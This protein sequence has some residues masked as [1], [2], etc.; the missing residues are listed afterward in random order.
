MKN[1]NNHRFSL[2]E[3]F[4]S[5]SN[6]I[7][8]ELDDKKPKPSDE[9][10]KMKSKFSR[11]QKRMTTQMNNEMLNQILEKTSIVAEDEEK[12]QGPS[13][14][15][16]E[17]P[18]DLEGPGDDEEDSLIKDMFYEKKEDTKSSKNEEEAAKPLITDLGDDEL[19]NE[20]NIIKQT[21]SVKNNPNEYSYMNK[22]KKVFKKKL[23]MK[24]MVFSSLMRNSSSQN[25]NGGEEQT[26]VLRT[27]TDFASSTL[28]FINNGNSATAAT[29]PYLVSVNNERSGKAGKG[30]TKGGS[31]N[32]Y[33]ILGVGGSRAKDGTESGGSIAINGASGRLDTFGTKGGEEDDQRGK[34]ALESERVGLLGGDSSKEVSIDEE[35]VGVDKESHNNTSTLP[36]NSRS[37]E[38]QQLSSGERTNTPSSQIPK[39]NVISS[40]TPLLGSH[41]GELMVIH[42][43]ETPSNEENEEDKENNI[44]GLA[45]PSSPINVKNINVPEMKQTNDSKKEGRMRRGDSKK[46]FSLIVGYSERAEF[47]E[48]SGSGEGFGS[49]KLF[50]NR[51]FGA[52]LNKHRSLDSSTVFES[53]TAME[54][55]AKAGKRRSTRI[56]T[57]M[58]HKSDPKIKRITEFNNIMIGD[59]NAGVENLEFEVEKL[60]KSFLKKEV[61]KVRKVCL[62]KNV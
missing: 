58:L 7:A 38:T 9:S 6:L 1:T 51:T 33:G 48:R 3:L 61:R 4:K 8:A 37:Q 28:P 15:S 30:E 27:D 53:T 49:T 20:T 47:S 16:K 45:R 13:Y 17:T 44:F 62:L 40:N 50:R 41:G 57:S 23:P 22:K 35:G 14:P 54:G 21:L 56:R 36:V 24:S 46:K 19:E 29:N 39:K 18:S 26:N 10:E 32:N 5:S 60:R 55:L 11:F 2:G 12:E 25:Q 43:D 34:E 42:E 52:Q 59:L 31:H